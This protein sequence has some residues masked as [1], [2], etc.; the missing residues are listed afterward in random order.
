LGIGHWSL[1]IG[2]GAGE[3]KKIGREEERKSGKSR[4]EGEKIEGKRVRR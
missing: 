3:K 4:R 2:Q 1:V